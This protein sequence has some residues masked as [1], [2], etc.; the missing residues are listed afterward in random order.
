[1]RI[2]M[3]ACVLL[4]AGCAAPPIVSEVTAFHTLAPNEATQGSIAIVPAAGVPDGI[5]FRTYAAQ[6]HQWLRPKGLVPASS[7]A[8]ADYIGTFAFSIDGG[9]RQA[10]SRPIYGQTGGGAAFTTGSFGTATTYVPPTFGAVGSVSGVVSTFNRRADLEIRKRK[11]GE[12]V[13]TGRNLSWGSTG[14]IAAVL[15]TMIQAMLKDFPNE[16]GKTKTVKLRD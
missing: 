16:S 10:V 8:N 12:I 4:V 7:T 13:W 15:P 3:I 14:E 5:E 1:M 2:T 11:T 6:I 9:T